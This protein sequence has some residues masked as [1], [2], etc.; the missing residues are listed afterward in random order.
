MAKK[1]EKFYKCSFIS[2]LLIL[3]S[4]Q[5]ILAQQTT[6]SE[7]IATGKVAYYQK[8]NMSYPSI[9]YD[10]LYF[11]RTKSIFYWNLNAISSSQATKRAKEGPVSGVINVES[12]IYHGLRVNLLNTVKDS[13]FSLIGMPNINKLLYVKEETAQ[14]KW[15]IK[16]STKYVGNYKVRKATAAFR[17]RHYTAWFTPKIPVPY[18]P[19]KLHGLPGLILQAYDQ[20]GRIYF[21]ATEI[22]FTN[23]GTIG[24]IPLTGS[25][26]V[27]TL[28]QYK[29]LLDNFKKYQ[30][31]STLKMIRPYVSSEDLADMTFHLPEVEQMEKFNKEEE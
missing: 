14:I 26:Q 13:L 9:Q 1:I 2:L 3:W 4:V 7:N 25:E 31:N 16:D 19:W 18:G 24:P 5:I 30:Q 17:G 28:D 10:T 27:I 6:V 11:N 22:I 29:E 21:S 15:S 8:V 20:S 23:I 12:K